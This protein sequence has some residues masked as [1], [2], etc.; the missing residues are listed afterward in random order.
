MNTRDEKD[1]A[2]RQVAS[3]DR[4][5]E[6]AGDDPLMGPGLRARREEFARKAEE[7]P[8]TPAPPRAVLFFTGPAV[9]GSSGIEVEFMT[10][11]LEHFQ[12][13]VKTQYAF[14]KHGKVGDRARQ[15]GAAESK[16]LLTG[17]PRGSFGIELSQPRAG[18]FL[19][20][21]Q[22][23]E[24]LVQVTRLIRAAGQDDEEFGA[25]LD[26]VPPR[27][28]SRLQRFFKVLADSNA[29]LRMES[30]P[31]RVKLDAREVAQ[32]AE[33]VSKVEKA[34]SKIELAGTFRGATLDT[35]RF[36]FRAQ[37]GRTISGRISSEVSDEDA[38]AMNQ[39]TNRECLATLAVT[40]LRPRGADPRERSDLLALRAAPADASL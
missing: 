6:W 25:E 7:S 5:L 30:G 12:Q 24:T 32:G 22:L 39:F 4:F 40:T 35:W 11:V 16:L 2:L 23:S 21:G 27:I 38:A 20:A 34:A 18:D 31:L 36:D 29:S 8:A 13:M 10:R 15:A 17:T 28:L 14:T 37:D 3:M 19:A 1:F 33:R 26:D 9:E